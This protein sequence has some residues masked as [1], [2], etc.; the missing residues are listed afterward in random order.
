V[1]GH[2][3]FLPPTYIDPHRTPLR[4]TLHPKLE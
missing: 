4:N 1:D 3:E 2:P